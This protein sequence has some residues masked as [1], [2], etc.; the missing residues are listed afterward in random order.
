MALPST[1]VPSPLPA[2]ASTC[3]ARESH[4]DELAGASES[5]LSSSGCATW[6]TSGL[7]RAFG[8]R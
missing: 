3:F 5:T 2:V 8:G 4:L 6:E 7:R 1:V